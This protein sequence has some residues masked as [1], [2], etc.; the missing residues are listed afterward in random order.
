MWLREET[1]SCS[2]SSSRWINSVPVS[3]N[4]YNKTHPFS[5]SHGFLKGT[6][7]WKQETVLVAKR[8]Q[9]TEHFTLHW[10]LHLNKYSRNCVFLTKSLICLVRMV[11]RCILFKRAFKPDYSLIFRVRSCQTQLKLSPLLIIKYIIC[12][13]LWHLIAAMTSFHTYCC[14]IPGRGCCPSCG[15]G[16]GQHTQVPALSGSLIIEALMLWC[17]AED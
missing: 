9:S 8:P 4:R 14:C 7:H 10:D 2:S 16:G 17:F 6:V 1:G 5:F 15:E 12:E 3:S 13:Q 11:R